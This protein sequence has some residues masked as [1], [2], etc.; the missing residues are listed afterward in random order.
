MV[1]Y[2][3]ERLE[4]LPARQAVSTPAPRR[5]AGQVLGVRR[6]RQDDGPRYGH[7]GWPARPRPLE[8]AGAYLAAGNP[9]LPPL[10]DIRA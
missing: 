1:R 7:A 2:G 3:M 5:V 4:T 6:L 9:P 10:V 8:V